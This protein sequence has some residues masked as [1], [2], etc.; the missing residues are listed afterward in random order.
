M[1]AILILLA[2]IQLLFLGASS[3]QDAKKDKLLSLKDSTTGV[4]TLNSNSYDRFTEGKRNY[5]LVVLLTAL[6]AQLNC[7]P[8]R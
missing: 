3:A 7:H 1:K 8:C 6:D 2:F 4:I 5:G